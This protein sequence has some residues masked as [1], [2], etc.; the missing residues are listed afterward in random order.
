MSYR[1]L[2]RV[3]RPQTFEDLIGQEHVTTTLKNALSEGHFSHAYLFSGPRGTGKTSAAKLLAKAVNCLKG[4]APEPCNQCEACR[5][6]TEGSLMDVVEIDAASNRGVDEI[7]DLRDKVKY[8]PSEVRYKVYIVDEV[9]M[10]TTEA[11]NALLKTLE[12]PPEH[13]LF[14]LATTEPHKLPST[15]VSR[16]Q[17]FSFRRHTMGNLLNHLRKICRSEG[18]EAE[19]AALAAIARSADGGMRDALS[20]L[21]QVLAFSDRHVDEASVLAVTGSVSR[22]TLGQLMEFCINRDAAAALETVDELLMDGLEPERLVHDWIHLSRDLLL[23]VAAPNLEEIRERMAGEKRWLELAEQTSAEDLETVLDILIRTQQ[24]MKWAPHPRILLEMTLVRLCQESEAAPYPSP[25]VRDEK[26]IL[27]LEEQLKK[28]EN[29]VEE[30]RRTRISA[31]RNVSPENKVEKTEGS[32][33]RRPVGSP[34]LETFLK[35]GSKERLQQVIRNWPEVL[36]E[37][38]E[39]KIT[40]HAWLIDGEPVAATEDSVLISFKNSI[41]RETT[42]KKPNKT[43]I[44]QV[45][46]D[47]LGTPLVLH[48]VMRAEWERC[49]AETETSAA[50]EKTAK[51]EPA[52]GRSSDDPVERA[53]ELFGEDMVEISD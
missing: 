26:K 41:H 50:L 47:V 30:L 9:H 51:E 20:L 31:G 25:E 48:T 14:I 28:L 36:A 8:A 37:V 19:D 40:V 29:K 45:I 21:D 38:K 2:Y 49:R 35:K 32:A 5:K 22:S 44:E 16:C 15:I 43:L 10:L 6:I 39:K 24:Q 11:F 53:V 1:A 4:P 12:E 42:E 33:D 7:R 52:K 18:I 34:R 23:L 3:W 17:R 46:K 13:V 27:H